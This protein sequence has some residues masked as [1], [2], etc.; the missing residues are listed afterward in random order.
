[1][2]ISII[3]RHHQASMLHAM[4]TAGGRQKILHCCGGQQVDGVLEVVA[5]QGSH[6]GTNTVAETWLVLRRV[7]GKIV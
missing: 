6:R 7:S 2:F 4:P 5:E 1:M 3:R